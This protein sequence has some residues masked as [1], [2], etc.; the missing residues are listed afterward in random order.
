M[1]LKKPKPDPRPDLPSVEQLQAET[2]RWLER[3]LG[4]KL[5]DVGKPVPID[6]LLDVTRNEP[7]FFKT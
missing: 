3:Q 4:R 6:P 1:K 5:P 7:P 2:H